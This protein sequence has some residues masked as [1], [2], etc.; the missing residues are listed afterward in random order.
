MVGELNIVIVGLTGQGII[1]ATR[2]LSTALLADGN[3]VLVAD[4]PP[5]SHRYT[6][7]YSF[8]RIGDSIQS[9]TISEGEA[10]LVIGLEPFECLKVGS[11]YA[12]EGGTVLMND[13]AID[14]RVLP[15]QLAE[16]SGYMYPS[17]DEIK[18][19]FQSLGVDRVEA[20]EASEIAHVEVG[21]RVAANMVMLGAAYAT[22][23][24][25]VKL[26]TLENIVE[27]F[28]PVGA[29]EKNLRAFRAGLQAI[30]GR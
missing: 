23:V 28:S 8:L 17:V 5:V 13:R 12:R 21:R 6:L 3:K 1:M 15:I 20:V 10:D 27:H 26:E 14:T 11:I 4:V 16:A 30:H 2:M 19:H 24:L 22:D 25:P 9:A 29:A 7:S 18:A